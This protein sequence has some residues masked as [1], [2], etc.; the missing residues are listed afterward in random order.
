MRRAVVGLALL[1]L[2]SGCTETV[3]ERQVKV[4]P[5][6][7]PIAYDQDVPRCVAM[8]PTERL[9]WRVLQGAAIGVGFGAGIGAIAGGYAAGANTLPAIWTGAA[10]GAGAGAVVGAGEGWKDIQHSPDGCAGQPSAAADK[11]PQ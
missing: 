11:P 6:G 8:S 7:A 10:A 3:R 5:A 2:V 9:A 4:I 1:V